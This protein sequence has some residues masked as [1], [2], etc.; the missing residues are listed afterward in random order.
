ME[1]QIKINLLK[2]TNAQFQW[3][4]L[5]LGVPSTYRGCYVPPEL[6]NKKAV[7]FSS[8]FW[9]QALLSH[10]HVTSSMGPAFN[11]QK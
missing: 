3:G 10:L 5:K 11:W 7:S 4:T 8:A 2:T 1:I 9:N 6:E